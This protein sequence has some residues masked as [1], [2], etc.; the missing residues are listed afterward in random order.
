MKAIVF[1]LDETLISHR[2]QLE[3]FIDFQYNHFYN[4]LKLIPFEDWKN[5]FIKLDNNGYVTKEVVYDNLSNIFKLE[6]S[7]TELYQHFL[8]NFHFYISPYK[9]ANELL[10][11]LKKYNLKLGLLTNGGTLIQNNKINMLKYENF[12]DEIIIS[13]S[14]GIEKPDP[15]IFDMILGRLKVEPKD[16]IY[17]GDHPF[18]DIIGA[19]EV[20]IKTIW[21]SHN[22]KWEHENNNPN[23]IANDLYGVE[24]IIMSEFNW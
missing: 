6:I 16:C 24:E 18:N 22:R 19:K 11:I 14:V 20:G 9:R 4:R 3:N 1:D 7:V 21:M 23:W 17:V 10:H 12:F 8:Q 13:E 15:R 5:N 2:K